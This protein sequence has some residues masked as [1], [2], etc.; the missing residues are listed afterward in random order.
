MDEQLE[1]LDG[2][3]TIAASWLCSV[4]EDETL[5]RF[6]SDVVQFV[7]ETTTT[8]TQNWDVGDMDLLKREVR[9]ATGQWI[10]MK[11]F[12]E[13]LKAAGRTGT[14]ILHDHYGNPCLPGQQTMSLSSQAAQADQY[15]YRNRGQP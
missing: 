8:W 12:Y 10:E 6:R 14:S 5:E 11:R 7:L 15:H 3:R 9:I 13:K 2:Y 4:P 1:E